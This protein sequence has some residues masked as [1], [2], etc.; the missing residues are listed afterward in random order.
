MK[1]AHLC[2]AVAAALI[3][4]ACVGN[5]EAIEKDIDFSIC[6]VGLRFTCHIRMNL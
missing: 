1:I 2:A 6:H 5:E 4:A 3:L